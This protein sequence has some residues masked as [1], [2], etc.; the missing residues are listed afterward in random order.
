MTTRTPFGMRHGDTALTAPP[1]RFT[2][3]IL[4]DRSTGSQGHIGHEVG[5]GSHAA[6]SADRQT[7]RRRDGV[8][9]Q[10]GRATDAGVC[11][12]GRAWT[13]LARRQRS[14]RRAASRVVLLAGAWDAIHDGI[15][16]ACGHR[17]EPYQADRTGARGR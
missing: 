3:N 6:W 12:R 7:D 11:T 2:A 1:L 8:G 14:R 10:T 9:S 4:A 17:R 15:V 5:A 13:F 16:R